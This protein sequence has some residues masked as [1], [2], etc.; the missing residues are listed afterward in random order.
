MHLPFPFEHKSFVMII[1][2]VGNFVNHLCF[3]TRHFLRIREIATCV[4]VILV[5]HLIDTD[6]TPLSI[7]YDM[8]LLI[9]WIDYVKDLV[10]MFCKHKWF[11]FISNTTK[12]HGGHAIIINLHMWKMHPTA[13]KYGDLQLYIVEL[14]YLFY[15]PIVWPCLMGDTI[16]SI[17]TD[18][19]VLI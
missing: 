5:N 6:D 4:V 16:H 17:Y 18:T 9:A 15:E 12:V 13:S 8:T 7:P 3:Y 10:N 14:S 11:A 19:T 2:D 1:V